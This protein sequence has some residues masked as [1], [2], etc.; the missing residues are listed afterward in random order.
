MQT[1]PAPQNAA[2]ETTSA[3]PLC[4][5]PVLPAPVWTPPGIELH[6]GGSF[7]QQNDVESHVWCCRHQQQVLHTAGGFQT[8]NEDPLQMFSFLL[9]KRPKHGRAGS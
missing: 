1:L 3:R 5:C 9:D 2:L 6:T 7:S 4:L 8:M